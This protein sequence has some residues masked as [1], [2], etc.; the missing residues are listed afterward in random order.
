MCGEQIAFTIRTT[1]TVK[2]SVMQTGWI[3]KL[4]NHNCYSVGTLAG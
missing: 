2:I 1:N 3:L 4:K